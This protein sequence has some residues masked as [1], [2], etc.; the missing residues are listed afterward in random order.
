[1]KL[2]MAE[3]RGNGTEGEDVT[4]NALVI[5][6]IQKALDA[7]YEYL[8]VRGEIY[9]KHAA[10][11]AFNKRQ[12]ELD[13]KLA[14]NPRN[15][16][17]GSLRQLDTSITKE[18]DL[19]ML[20]F[21]VQDGPETLMSHHT[22]GL[23]KL[24]GLGIK[25]VYHALCATAEDVIEQIDKIAE[26]RG[27][28]DYDIDGAVIKIEQTEYRADFSTSSKYSPGHIA[29]KYPPEEKP[30][31]LTYVEETIGRTGKL[32]FIGHV[33][34]PETKKPVRLCGTNVS[35]VTLHNQD[36]INENKLGIGGIYLLKKSGD[37]IP[38][39]C[40]VV[41]EPENVYIASENCPVCGQEMVKEEDTADIRCVN[42]SCPA[43]LT[44]TISYFVSLDCMNVMGLGEKYI[45]ALIAEGYLKSY[46]DLYKLKEHRDEL[47]EKGI[48][49]KVKNTDKLLGL[50]ENS[51]NNS[52][53]QLL[54]ALG[55]RNVGKRSAKEIMS[56]FTS[57]QELAN[58]SVEQL[59]GI[60]DVGEITAEC[61]HDFFNNEENKKVLEA[62][63]EAGVNT[64]MP[65]EEKASDSLAGLTFVITGTLPSMGRKEAQELIEKNGGKVT[66]SVSK[67]TNYLLAGE[68]AGSK[69]T[70]A[71]SLGIAIITEEQLKDM[72]K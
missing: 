29:Y 36:Y 70:K 63:Y 37:I 34:D 38:K 60:Q 54:A 46:A 32:G 20:V 65:K 52:P 2:T 68:D 45:E 13:K 72:I 11:E 17:A 15:L 66:G 55:I 4:P 28:L 3:T 16:A 67:K 14:A 31:E 43:Q 6:D 22:E 53:V 12:E 42:S 27:E 9:M 5:D 64:V 50:I 48:I 56:N 47:I 25:T 59:I 62:L 40:G 69:L 30:V 51:K 57:I 1:M 44:R 35:R 21:N 26:M 8:E 58:A 7:E 49:G 39:I 23:D 24:E 10:F 33:Y 61:I 18:R 41:K 71:Q 19:S